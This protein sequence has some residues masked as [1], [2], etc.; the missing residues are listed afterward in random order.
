MLKTNLSSIVLYTIVL[1]LLLT[2]PCLAVYR[3]FDAETVSNDPNFLAHTWYEGKVF[4]L[5][6]YDTSGYSEVRGVATAGEYTIL[7]IEEYY[8]VLQRVRTKEL[9]VVP[10]DKV[11]LK[12]ADK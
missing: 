3:P 5:F 11:I 8:Y 2:T 10:I 9:L 4:N 7:S 12:E 1:L 6:V